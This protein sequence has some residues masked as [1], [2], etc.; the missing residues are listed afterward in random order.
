MPFS[1]MPRLAIPFPSHTKP[2]FEVIRR[3]ALGS[4]SYPI[5]Y[6]LPH[7]PCKLSA[8]CFS[9]TYS[10][11]AICQCSITLH[12][13]VRHAQRCR[14]TTALR[15]VDRITESLSRRRGRPE[16]R[17]R[18]G[19]PNTQ[20]VWNALTMWNT[21]TALEYL[22]KLSY[23]SFVNHSEKLSGLSLNRN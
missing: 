9:S 21:R 10:G 14:D 15:A 17:K 1:M 2:P 6:S 4:A 12:Y 23:V 5:L 20:V 7:L 11:C 8:E 22:S 13:A 16:H 18:R 19:Y 3:S